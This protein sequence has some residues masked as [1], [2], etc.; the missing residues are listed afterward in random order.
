MILTMGRSTFLPH[1]S[2]GS[3]DGSLTSVASGPLHPIPDASLMSVRSLTQ[4]GAPRS[5]IALA[6]VC[7][8]ILL[9]VVR[10]WSH[11]A[12]SRNPF[13]GRP[14][15]VDPTSQ[16]AQ[17]AQVAHQQGRSD[18]DVQQRIAE[19][20]SGIWLNPETLDRD[21]VREH[22]EFLLRDARE[23][24]AAV[25]FV[26]YGITDRDCTG[27]HSAGGL[28]PADYLAWV[29]QIASGIDA[30]GGWV[31]VIVEPD[32]L[33]S[34]TECSDAASRLE[35]LSQAVD[36]LASAGATVYID[37]G[38]SDWVSPEDM[39]RWLSA[40]G[41]TRVR[42]FATNVSA[43]QS[44][45]DEIAYAMELSRLLDGARF[46]IDTSRNGAGTSPGED[47]CNPAGQALGAEPGDP[48]DK[49]P[50][51]ARL[52]VKPPGES[53]GSCGG[54]PPAGTW[55]PERAVQLARAAGW[56]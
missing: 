39:A 14:L 13:E 41:V 49:S 20:A 55:W 34:L 18:A 24:D 1:D 52:W 12:Q 31:A 9:L 27:E 17:A 11:G 23:V 28:P 46:V 38:H 53:D 16:A 48:H 26:V 6:T 37:A 33:A 42:G 3:S 30:V 8:V 4:G 21:A 36:Q 10:P 40:V 25:L 15:Y 22:V 44:E 32:A 45:V 54:G 19:V 47:W 56:E 43:Y 50:L 29:D 7:A 5:L 2:D 35:L 51:D